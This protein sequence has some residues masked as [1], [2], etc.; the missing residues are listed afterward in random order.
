MGRLAAL[1]MCTSLYHYEDHNDLDVSAMLN[2]LY[3]ICPFTHAVP[4]AT[5]LSKNNKLHVVLQKGKFSSTIR[6]SQGIIVQMMLKF[7]VIR[8][9]LNAAILSTREQ[10]R[11]RGGCPATAPE[12]PDGEE[13]AATTLIAV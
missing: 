10:T 5:S 4:S 6:Y 13:K 12:E 11:G 1:T 7:F 2:G 3:S 9:H 8:K